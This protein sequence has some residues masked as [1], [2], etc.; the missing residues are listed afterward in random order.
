MT[1]LVTKNQIKFVQSLH[2]KKY[3]QKY[4]QFIVEGAKSVGELIHSS[5]EIESIYALPDWLNEHKSINASLSI[6]EASQKD[7]E[8][9]SFFKT[10]SSVIA[11]AKQ[12]K[13]AI[14]EES[15][16]VICLDD[17]KDP[18]NLGTIV[19]IADWY[20]ISTIYASEQTVDLYNPKTISSTMGSFSR[21]DVLYGDLES[22]LKNTAK[23]VFYA[24]MDGASLYEQ[25]KLEKGMLVIGSEANGIS[26]ALLSL[27]HTAI[28]IPKTGGAESLNAAVATAI[29]CDRLLR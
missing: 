29:I 25:P 18:G 26:D 2:R 22:V 11:I 7:L 19:R 21:V 9:M 1:N 20:G 14:V 6:V 24:L 12:Q 17:I 13:T 4:S 3:R 27:N 16:W 15:D 5:Y 23:Q 10:A 8:R 28:T